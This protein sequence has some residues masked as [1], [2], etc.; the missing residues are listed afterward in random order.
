LIEN[1]RSGRRR[2]KAMDFAL[3]SIIKRRQESE[4]RDLLSPSLF[5][6]DS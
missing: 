1:K 5:I 2:E 4:K 6:Y 3:Y